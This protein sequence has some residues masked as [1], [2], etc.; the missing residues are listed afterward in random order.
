[1]NAN[2]I[3]V[4]VAVFAAVTSLLLLCLGYWSRED[5]QINQRVSGLAEEGSLAVPRK[6][7]RVKRQFQE[8]ATKSAFSRLAIRLL[9]T[10]MEFRQRLQTR[11]LSA[12][13]YS[14]N[15]LPLFLVAKIVLTCSPPLIGIVASV[16]GTIDP[17][18]GL[19]WG[20]V[21]GIIGLTL[22]TLWLRAQK[23]KWHVII[24]RSLS[25]FLDLMVSCLEVGLSSEAALQRVTEELRYAHP[26]LWAELSVVQAQIE[27][28]TSSDV[29]MMNFADRSDCESVR[30]LAV[31]L[32]QGRR[33][34]GGVA[35]VFR[36]QAENLRIRREHAVEEKSQQAAIKILIP[37]L[38]FI[39]PVIFVVLAGPAVIKVADM[40]GVSKASARSR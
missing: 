40:F 18:L 35:E 7:V 31:V 14:A 1:M 29:A 37:T 30:S 28:G 36:Q 25:D 12:G 24:N 10:G 39:F 34:G 22:P 20:S 15:A 17:Y 38:L 32:Q 16:Y 2:V 26:R 6:P 11:L 8:K 33:L 3:I 4:S 21:A 23:R 13:I 5:S 9:P 19:L 27:L